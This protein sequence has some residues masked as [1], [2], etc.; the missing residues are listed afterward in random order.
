MDEQLLSDLRDA[1]RKDAEN[2]LTGVHVVDVVVTP[3][4]SMDEEELL[5]VLI[6]YDAAEKKAPNPRETLGLRR[7]VRRHF[8]RHHITSLPLYSFVSSKEYR[9]AVDAAN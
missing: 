1:I 7:I 4:E 6:L 8:D 9:V 3:M 5:R 2:N